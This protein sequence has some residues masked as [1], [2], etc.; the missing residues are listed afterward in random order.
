MRNKAM[1]RKYF[2]AYDKLLKG[3][4]R[5][6]KKLFCFFYER[7]ESLL[8]CPLSYEKLTEPVILPSG[9]TINQ[10]FCE[11]LITTN[12]YDPYNSTL[13]IN[14]IIINRF[15]KSVKEIYEDIGQKH[16]LLERN[17]LTNE[18]SCQTAP[19]PSTHLLP[20]KIA[21]HSHPQ[22]FPSPSCSLSLSRPT[23]PPDPQTFLHNSTSPSHRTPLLNPSHPC[24][25]THTEESPSFSPAKAA[26]LPSIA[27]EA[28]QEFCHYD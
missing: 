10:N 8:D 4:N 12:C 15:T 19:I 18:A 20:P 21:L 13:K 22:N 17:T 2:K 25:V 11:K 9:I 24:S 5:D 14:S 7:I 26:R 3:P 6:Y 28:S 27:A 16:L 1:K 23:T